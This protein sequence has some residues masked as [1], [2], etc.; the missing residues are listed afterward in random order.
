MWLDV[1]DSGV[2]RRCFAVLESLEQVQPP[3]APGYAATPWPLTRQY[4]VVCER[5]HRAVPPWV[6][7]LGQEDCPQRRR[8]PCRSRVPRTTGEF[9]SDPTL[10]GPWLV[11]RDV[12]LPRGDLRSRWCS[13]ACRIR[14]VHS[15]PLG[16][17]WMEMYPILRGRLALTSFGQRTPTSDRCPQFL[18]DFAG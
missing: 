6:L 11:P 15:R 4:L 5:W 1:L 10:C 16:G 13:S 2:V 9:C 12:R 14:S 7:G 3:A 8:K 17:R 18:A